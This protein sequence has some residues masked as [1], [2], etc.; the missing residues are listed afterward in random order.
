MMAE[1]SR[2]S[3]IN[4]S[5]LASEIFSV[6]FTAAD[7][8][9]QAGDQCRLQGVRGARE[10][11]TVAQIEELSF[12]L[13]EEKKEELLRELEALLR[14]EQIHLLCLLVTD[15]NTQNSILLVCGEKWFTKLIDYP[16][17]SEMRGS[18]MA[19]SRARSN[20]CLT[21]PACW[22]GDS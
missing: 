13:F 9:G 21:S 14:R 1:L 7:H 19:W 11:F 4:P 16:E 12:A 20:S 5:D 2:L 8:D 15:V 18:S 17:V 3:G 10:T 22:P 6:R